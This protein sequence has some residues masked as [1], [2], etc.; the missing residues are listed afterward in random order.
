[1]LQKRRKFAS[2]GDQDHQPPSQ[3]LTTVGERVSKGGR[4]RGER[5]G[6]VGHEAEDYDCEDSLRDAD[7]EG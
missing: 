5:G 4:E 7:G 1:M 3:E 6:T 2:E